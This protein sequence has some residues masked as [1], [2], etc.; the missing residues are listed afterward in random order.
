MT[1]LFALNAVIEGEFFLPGSGDV[2]VGQDADAPHRRR[3]HRQGRRDLQQ[4][5]INNTL[6]SVIV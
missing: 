2:A 5:K 1:L 4:N 3:R 6:L